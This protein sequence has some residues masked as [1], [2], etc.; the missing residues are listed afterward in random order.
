MNLDAVIILA[1]GTAKRL[2]G[3]SKPDFIVSGERLIDMVLAE[4]TTAAPTIS[5]R[6]VVGPENLTVPNDVV[7]TL[8]DPPFGG[9][10]AGIGAGVASLADLA[11]D[12]AVLLGTCD[13]PLAPRLAPELVRE[14]NRASE[15]EGAARVDGAV[16]LAAED[17]YPQ[18]VH[19][20]YRLGALREISMDRDRSIRAAFRGLRL[21]TIADASEWCMDVDDPAQ[22]EAMEIRLRAE[23]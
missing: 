1:G 10:L 4:V 23:R 13:A 20:L 11:D 6:V 15:V 22:A 19:G 14:L 17:A 16:A 3:V 12:A 2:G 9:P 8:E 7:L 18:Y 5:H 21:A